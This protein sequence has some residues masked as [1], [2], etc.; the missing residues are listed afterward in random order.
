MVISHKGVFKT[1][2]GLCGHTVHK[3]HI[4]QYKEVKKENVPICT[5]NN[6]D[7]QACGRIWP[8]NSMDNHDCPTVM[9]T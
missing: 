7:Q 9:R 4:H 3:A 6:P 5:M 2:N 1:P 8:P